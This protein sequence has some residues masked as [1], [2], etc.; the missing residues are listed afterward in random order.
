MTIH[1]I[2]AV[3]SRQCVA[4]NLVNKLQLIQFDD[5]SW[6][7]VNRTQFT[8]AQREHTQRTRIKSEKTRHQA[9]W[10]CAQ[11]EAEEKSMKKL[12]V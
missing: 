7:L 1:R 2:H 4:H 8:L 9:A 10:L 12:Y 3:T 6:F 5:G 11:A